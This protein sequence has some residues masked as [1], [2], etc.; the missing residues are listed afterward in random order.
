MA[1]PSTR[2]IRPQY[3]IQFFIGKIDLTMRVQ[4]ITIINSIKTIYPVF[5]IKILLSSKDYFLEQLYGQED[6]HIQVVVTN[7]DSQATETTEVDL[8]VVHMDNKVSSQKNSDTNNETNQLEDAVSVIALMK[9]P[10]L[11]FS[12]TVNFLFTE[13]KSNSTEQQRITETVNG[14]FKPVGTPID[15]HNP[16][17]VDQFLIDNPTFE[18]VPS[19]AQAPSNT[20]SPG[21][22]QFLEDNPTFTAPSSGGGFV[23]Q[24]VT[25]SVSSPGVDQFLADNPTFTAAPPP[26]ASNGGF[27]SQGVTDSGT[28]AGVDQ[29]LIDNPTFTASTPSGGFVSQGVTDSNYKTA[30]NADGSSVKSPSPSGG[31]ESFVDTGTGFGLGSI[32]N[33]SFKNITQE[34]KKLAKKNNKA[35]GQSAAAGPPGKNTPI[36]M[37]SSLFD[38]Y[39]TSKDIKKNIDFNNCNAIEIKQAVVPP[40]SFIGCIRHINDKYG[41]FKGPM[42]VYCDLENSVNIWDITK[43]SE[44][45]A[46]YS[47]DFLALGADASEIMKK[48]TEGDNKFYTYNPLKVKNNTNANMMKAGFEHV[49]IKKPRNKFTETVVKTLD[50]VAK[51]FKIIQNPLLLCNEVARKNKIISNTTGYSSDEDSDDAYMTSRLSAYIASC[52]TFTFNLNGNKLPIKKL[53]KVGSC[54]E[55]VPHITEYL[56]YSGKYVVGSSVIQLSREET[57]HYSCKVEVTCFRES[58]ES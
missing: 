9:E 21:Q 56:K 4:N 49:L 7:E 15:T 19:T 43:V 28:S 51:G 18:A 16:P 23:S 44:Q 26:A 20:D 55:L 14:G 5:L 24:G 11:A 58:L 1:N 46:L 37:V 10:Y 57:G 33:G 30:F 41:L 22:A 45:E 31:M 13:S 39:I 48:S 38:K 29:F 54:V 47:V 3:T 40:R 52:S 50:D 27:V 53:C 17:G 36:N 8:I 2:L 42:M 25:D 6:A 12:K 34:N 35:P 32:G